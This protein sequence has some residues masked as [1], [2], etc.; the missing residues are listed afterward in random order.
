MREELGRTMHAHG[1][2]ARGGH[3]RTDF[4][5]RDDGTWLRHIAVWSD[6]TGVPAITHHP[7]TVTRWPVQ[8]RSY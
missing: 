6:G 1:G 2:M 3:F 7:V 8:A 5:E 4:P